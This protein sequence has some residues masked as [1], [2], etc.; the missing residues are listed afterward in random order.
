M[1][2]NTA[3]KMTVHRIIMIVWSRCCSCAIL[4][5]PTGRFNW[6]TEGP[7]GRS[8]TACAALLKAAPAASNR[9]AGLYLLRQMLFIV[10]TFLQFFRQTQ[11]CSAAQAAS[12]ATQR[13]ANLA[14]Q[15][16]TQLRAYIAPHP[17]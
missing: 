3:T 5:T 14:R 6:R 2:A 9:F 16:C 8:L 1:T 12:S 13:H 17:D 7:P 4:V 15:C 10:F 11:P